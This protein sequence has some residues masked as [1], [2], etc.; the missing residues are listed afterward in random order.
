MLNASMKLSILYKSNYTLI[1]TEN[2]NSF[3]IYIVEA[4]ELIK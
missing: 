2:N 1:V 4:K 3:K